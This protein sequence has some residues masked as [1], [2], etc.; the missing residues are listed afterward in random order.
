MNII[1]KK[2]TYPMYY[3]TKIAAHTAFAQQRLQRCV[4]STS[5]GLRHIAQKAAR[6]RVSK[7]LGEMSWL[8]ESQTKLHLNGV[9]FGKHI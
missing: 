9:D 1:K 7:A 4:R 5:L 2:Q 3:K 8:N 6:R